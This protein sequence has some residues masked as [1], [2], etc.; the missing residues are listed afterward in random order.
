MLTLRNSIFIKRVPRFLEESVNNTLWEL[1]Y[2]I[3]LPFH[4]IQSAHQIIIHKIPMIRS[5]FHVEIDYNL[6]TIKL[7]SIQTKGMQGSLLE[8]MNLRHLIIC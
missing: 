8:L 4:N 6:L 7:I 3:Y 2:N 5:I 1:K